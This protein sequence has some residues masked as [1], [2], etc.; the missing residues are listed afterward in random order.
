MH[1]YSYKNQQ[2]PLDTERNRGKN[3]SFNNLVIY[4]LDKGVQN[5][6]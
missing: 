5:K 6:L 2:G 3:A 1:R 4:D